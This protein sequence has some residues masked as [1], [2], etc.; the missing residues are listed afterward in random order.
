MNAD[1]PTPDD[2]E[3]PAHPP[4]VDVPLAEPRYS[5]FEDLQGILLASLQA[6]LGIHLLRAAG[7]MTGGTAGLALVIAYATGWNFSVT[8]FLINI[9]FFGIAFWARGAVFFVK[10][11]ASSVRRS[12]TFPASTSSAK[13]TAI[14]RLLL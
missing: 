3:R 9:P 7:L 4:H 5:L 14:S 13:F 11:I 10:S 12:V 2:P 6:A 8:F 1:L